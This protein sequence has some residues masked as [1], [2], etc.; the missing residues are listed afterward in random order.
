MEKYLQKVFGEKKVKYRGIMRR[1][2]WGYL[3]RCGGAK[4]VSRKTKKRV[5]TSAR[6]FRE[7]LKEI[8]G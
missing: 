3:K 7:K 5:G 1:R 2:D 4:G 6:L 8:L